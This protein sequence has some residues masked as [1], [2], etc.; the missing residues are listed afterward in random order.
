MLNSGVGED[1][2]SGTMIS[3]IATPILPASVVTPIVNLAAPTLAAPPLEQGVTPTQT[4]ATPTAAAT[5]A[6]RQPAETLQAMAALSQQA[7][8]AAALAAATAAAPPASSTRT[9]QEEVLGALE[10]ELNLG[11]TGARRSLRRSQSVR[12]PVKKVHSKREKKT[13]L[14]PA[15]DDQDDGGEDKN[16]DEEMDDLREDLEDEKEKRRDCESDID[17]M[18]FQLSALEDKFRQ[19]QH[20]V[21]SEQA[22]ASLSKEVALQAH[23]LKQIVKVLEKDEQM[24]G[25]SVVILKQKA[26]SMR[27][28]H[29]LR[30]ELETFLMDKEGEKLNARISSVF[31]AGPFVW[32]LCKGQSFT[33]VVKDML[34]TWITTKQATEKTR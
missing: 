26:I 18:D 2:P 16:V 25:N 9:K 34:T 13:S 1:V 19:L 3:G 31:A 5:A 24:F 14:S 20:D 7:A 22:M 27:S 10:E 17:R 29:E 23:V 4:Y 21:V 28:F 6:M 33:Q 12:R 30:A 15:R 11:D 32:I 8:A